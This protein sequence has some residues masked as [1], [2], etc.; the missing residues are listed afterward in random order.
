M[1]SLLAISGRNAAIRLSPIEKAIAEIT[2]MLAAST[3]SPGPAAASR[4]VAD[5]QATEDSSKKR[6]LLARTSAIAPITGLASST[7]RLAA[8]MARVHSR[9]AV[10]G[11]PASGTAATTPTK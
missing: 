6:F 3:M 10:P 7:Q 9:V 2:S 5:T 8:A 1:L 4:A 11:C